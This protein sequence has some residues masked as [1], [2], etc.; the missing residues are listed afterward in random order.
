M[1]LSVARH[2]LY[3]HSLTLSILD[4]SKMILLDQVC[5]DQDKGPNRAPDDGSIISFRN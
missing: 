3:N 2:I 1:F 4:D 5:G